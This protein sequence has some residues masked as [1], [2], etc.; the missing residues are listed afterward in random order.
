MGRKTEEPASFHFGYTEFRVLELEGF[1]GFGFQGISQL[2]SPVFARL[3]DIESLL[4]NIPSMQRS[5]HILR[6]AESKEQQGAQCV[7]SSGLWFAAIR[8]YGLGL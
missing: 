3:L 6:Y 2:L 1:T 5:V 4:L 7:Q 8:I